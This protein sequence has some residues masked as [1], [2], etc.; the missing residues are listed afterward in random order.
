MPKIIAR[1]LSVDFPIYGANEPSLKR[2]IIETATGGVLGRQNNSR[3]SIVKAISNAS[4]DINEGDR[5]GLVGHNGSGKSTLL[6]ALAGIYEPTNGTIII[7]GRVTSMLS[8]TVGMSAEATGLEN[9]YM[10]GYFMGL[11]KSKIESLVDEIV[12][13]AGIGDYLY[14]PMKTYS[15]GMA[16]RLAF[17]VST[18]V[19]SDIVLMDEWLSVGDADFLN[20]AEARLTAVVD[21]ARIVVLASHDQGLISRRCNRVFNL[22]HGS[23]SESFHDDSAI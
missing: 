18:S 16:M 14:F 19:D 12:E 4:F 23:L 3:S 10:R 11:S 1:N 15:S 6:R 5:I 9:I 21:K 7:S 13:F 17:A 22:I 20:K 2:R 8:L